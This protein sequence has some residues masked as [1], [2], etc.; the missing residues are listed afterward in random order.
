VKQMIENL[1]KQFAT[2]SEVYKVLEKDDKVTIDFF[3]KKDGEA[4]EGGTANDIYVIIGSGQMIPG[5]EDVI[6]GRK[7]GEQK[8]ITV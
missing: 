6:I 5:F 1:R 7:K 2:F 3:G 4:F 8:T